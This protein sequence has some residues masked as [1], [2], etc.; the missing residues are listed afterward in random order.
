VKN[1]IHLSDDLSLPLDAATQTIAVIARKGAG[2]TYAASK[3]AEEFLAHDVQVVV[4]D[5]VGNWY[6]LRIGADG[7]SSGFDI[8][9]LG[10]LRGDAPIT[11]EAGALIADLVVDTGRSFILDL[12][13]FSLGA[14]KKFATAF[15]EQLWKRKK[16]Q[17]EPT[18]VHVFLEECQLI[19]PQF[20]G[21]D[22]ARMVG[23]WEEIVR[24]GRNYGIGATM[25]TQR[26]QSVN[27]EVLTQTECLLVLQVNGV[28]ERKALKEWIVHQGAAVDLLEELPS[29]EVGTAYLWSPQWLRT[30]RKIRIAKK[31]TFDASATPKVGEKRVRAEL[32]PLDL[33][34]LQARIAEVTKRAEENDPTALHRQVRQLQAELAKAKAAKPPPPG[35][36]VVK[37]VQVVKDQQVH[38]LEAA[39]KALVEA[40]ERAVGQAKEILGAL[41]IITQKKADLA[42]GFTYRAK[43]VPR[44]PAEPKVVA[45]HPDRPPPLP[46]AADPRGLTINRYALDLLR[47]V[48]QRHPMKLSRAQISTLSGRS[49]RSSA[50]DGAMAE[51][52]KLGHLVGAGDGLFELSPSGLELAGDAVG[53]GGQ[54]SHEVIE[55][56]RRVLPAYERTLFEALLAHHPKLLSRAD[57]AEAS[58][59]S[60]TSSAF[61]G[62]ISALKKNGLVTAEDGF[63]RLT[64]DLFM[65]RVGM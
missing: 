26:P 32:K 45:P 14:R 58:R 57:L 61:D 21:R 35:P 11:P 49:P 2:K 48:A 54:S 30:F 1:P 23:I 63:L 40:S 7:K 29:L 60:I 6:G 50:F 8:P 3:L 12:S 44:A 47:T 19:I 27:K 34:E 10:G 62:A 16:G 55:T 31:K 13:Q 64:N 22:D 43:I 38:R 17:S 20:V 25:I 56:W 51:L 15:G 41:W 18:P 24:L 5:T 33:A 59:K 37:E 36:T 28:P 53:A 65:D 9:V 46:A 42:P 4:M 39:A 52:K